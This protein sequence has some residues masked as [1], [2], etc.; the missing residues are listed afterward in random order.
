[1]TNNKDFKTTLLVSTYKWSR[2]EFDEIK[3]KEVKSRKEFIYEVSVRDISDMAVV[4]HKF[5]RKVKYKKPT[6]KNW[7]TYRTMV[8]RLFKEEVTQ[9]FSETDGRLVAVNTLVEAEL[10]IEKNS[11]SDTYSPSLE[12]TPDR[13]LPNF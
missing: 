7:Y 1:M 2:N 11:Y 13:G 5:G 4:F 12:W 9:K 8:N 10:E 6:D 3:Q